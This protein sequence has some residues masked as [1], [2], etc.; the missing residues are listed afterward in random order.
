MVSDLNLINQD[1]FL[2][3]MF[4]DFKVFMVLKTM[5]VDARLHQIKFQKFLNNFLNYYLQTLKFR[6]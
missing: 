1:S 6:L 2:A 3:D 5:Q 4:F